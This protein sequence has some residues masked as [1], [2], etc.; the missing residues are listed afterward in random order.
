MQPRLMPLKRA[1]MPLPQRGLN[2][3]KQSARESLTGGRKRKKVMKLVSIVRLKSS[4]FVAIRTAGAC[5][6]I[7]GYGA[8]TAANYK[9]SQIRVVVEHVWL[10]KALLAARG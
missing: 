6:A 10:A 2:C 4:S 9:P 8:A 5:L 7:N 3:R 1:M